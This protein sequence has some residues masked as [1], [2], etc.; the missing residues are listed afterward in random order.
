MN[1]RS[2][3]LVIVA[4]FVMGCAPAKPEPKFAR[5]GDAAPAIGTTPIDQFIVGTWTT[6]DY[7]DPQL[8]KQ[9][10][11]SSIA[12][13]QDASAA[14]PIVDIYEFKADG[15]FDISYGREHTMI[16][17]KWAAAQNT[18][19]LTYRQLNGKPIERE[20]ERLLKESETG[21]QGAIKNEILTDFV[22]TAQT[23]LTTLVPGSDPKLL[24]FSSSKPSA[25]EG[26]PSGGLAGTALTRL[27]KE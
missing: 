24:V 15:T 21:R 4:C 5:M 20:R 11:L 14:G 16:S 23:K 3:I 2:V 6:R 9:L 1:T 25:T 10:G 17:G 18:V 8:A 12:E 26:M 13:Q 22:V 19:T 27:K 7:T